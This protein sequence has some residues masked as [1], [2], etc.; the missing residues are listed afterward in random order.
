MA[1]ARG[2]VTF[3]IESA[4]IWSKRLKGGAAHAD[5]ASSLVV[6]ATEFQS[7]PA[8]FNPPR[9]A[10]LFDDS[11]DEP[12]PW[13]TRSDLF[14]IRSHHHETGSRS[15]YADRL[16]TLPLGSG[17]LSA[18]AWSDRLRVG[19]GFS[20]VIQRRGDWH[21]VR[22]N[23]ILALQNRD[24]LALRGEFSPKCDFAAGAG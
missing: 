11:T 10:E 21:Y 13:W 4:P 19:I 16:L 18:Y 6:F 7:V 9:P 8:E 3:V 22:R 2:N 14:T 20:H 24:I 15:S 23:D 17:R 1:R 5:H 12:R